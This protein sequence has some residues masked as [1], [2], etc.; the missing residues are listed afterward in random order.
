MTC[1]DY[2]NIRH[3]WCHG[4]S[5]RAAFQ[6]PKVSSCL[7]PGTELSKET[8]VLTKQETIGKGCPGG[9]PQCISGQG[10]WFQSGDSANVPIPT[11]F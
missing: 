5:G 11:V 6:G 9:E 4:A 1:G 8:G 2:F 7:T 3:D 10:G